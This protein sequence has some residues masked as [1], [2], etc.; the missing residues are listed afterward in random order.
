MAQLLAPIAPPTSELVEI[1]P[2]TGEVK[3]NFH[4]GQWR[5][6]EA[7]ERFVVILAGTQGGK[8]SFL[9]WWLYREIER[10]GQGDYLIAA[11]TYKILEPKILPTFLDVFA[12]LLSLGT[13]VRSPVMRF[14]FSDEG[15]RRTFGDR[16][17]PNGPPTVIYFGHASNP[18]SLES[19]T[20]KA[21]ALDEAGQDDFKQGSWEAILRRLSLAT[22]TGGGRVLIA[23]TVYNLGWIK[24]VLYDRKI[25]D[26]DP[27]IAIIHFDSTENPK[28]PKAEF[29][30]ARRDLPKWRF[31]MFYRGRFTRPA[32][33][34]YDSYDEERHERARTII[35]DEW[36]RYM[37]LDFGPVN[38]AAVFL[39]ER[40]E[41]K[42]LFLYRTYHA[43]GRT[44]KQHAVAM[45]EG[46]PKHRLPLAYGGSRSEQE[47][48]NDFTAAGLP[49][50]PSPIIDVEIG[51]L[52][53][54]GVHK[55]DEMTVFTDLDE[56]RAQKLSYSRELDANDEVT[57]A[58]KD[59]HA[60]HILDAERYILSSIR[61]GA[62]QLSGNP[63]S[64]VRETGSGRERR[65]SILGKP[66]SVDEDGRIVRGTPK[67]GADL[68]GRIER[69]AF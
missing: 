49:V 61:P 15:A 66:I 2:E 52:R 64:L 48:R 68:T 5:A 60:Y 11:P 18:D 16:Y 50:A 24:A 56:Y 55:R 59:K 30:R 54:W 67:K 10:Q 29:E 20:Y 34:I 33:M 47:W 65:V 42:H 12:R 63:G 3:L 27:S 37:G 7:E 69:R 26:N 28:F 44:A 6:W 1:S 36:K 23:T 38:T 4:P 39:A 51:I 17:D 21:A 53:V 35:P 31:D 41:D 43:G 22:A 13:F 58:I 57:E 45:M 62:D 8:S 46:E 32:G 14:T 25:R 40:P 9:P 19:A